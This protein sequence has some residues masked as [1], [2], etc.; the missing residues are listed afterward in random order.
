MKGLME[1]IVCPTCK[2]T[3]QLEV[4]EQ[5]ERETTTERLYCPKCCQYYSIEEGLP[6]LSPSDILVKGDR[7]RAVEVPYVFAESEGQI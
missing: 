1:I 6:N 7:L 2:G 3:L 4:S 5:D